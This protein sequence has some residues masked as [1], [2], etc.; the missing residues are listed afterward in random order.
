MEFEFLGLNSA[1]IGMSG[2]LVERGVPRTRRGKNIIE[3]PSPALIKITN[4]RNRNISLPERK[5]NFSLPYIESLWIAL[6]WNNL[7][8]LPGK[9]VK[10]LYNFSDD[11]STWRGGYGPRIRGYTGSTEQYEVGEYRN[12]SHNKYTVDQLSYVVNVLQEDPSSRQ[13]IISIGDPI[14]DSFDEKGKLLKT[15]D[16]PCT[17]SLH[18]MINDGKLDLY[19]HMRSN[20]LWWGFSA[21]N[22]PNFTLM[23]EYV[24][25]VLGVEMGSYYHMAD[26]FH[27][28]EPFFIKAKELYENNKH[29]M[30]RIH[31][32]DYD[33]QIGNNDRLTFEELDQEFFYL[34]ELEAQL[35]DEEE[36]SMEPPTIPFFKDW[37]RVIELKILMFHKILDKENSWYIDNPSLGVVFQKELRG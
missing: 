6:G 11:G 30:N 8:D 9:Y 33:I 20:D 7:N 21:V 37:F 36:L 13:A 24:S 18:F 1:L 28:Y 15:V 29:K 31:S 16:Y 22:V 26:N 25:M 5:W 32:G 17:R 34:R 35:W 2:A 12:R 19:T 10:N 23:Q 27:V 3:L 4:P 14:K